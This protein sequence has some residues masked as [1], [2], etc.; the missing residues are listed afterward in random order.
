MTKT[1]NRRPRRG[2]LMAGISIAAFLTLG[3]GTALAA[4]DGD[5]EE[6]TVDEVVVT[7]SLGK[8]RT[9]LESAVPIDA[10]SAEDIEAVS[11]GDTQDILK[12]L[13]PS[14][15]LPRLPIA[16]GAT[17]I[18]PASLRGLSTDKTLLLVNSK[19]RHRGALVST[20]GDGAQPAD[21]AQI[22]A[23]ALKSVEVLRD[24]AGAQYGSDAIAGV[25]NFILKDAPDGGM[26]S[27]QAGQYY[28]G[29]GDEIVIGGN[30]GFAIGDAGFL[31]FSFEYVSLQPTSRGKQICN[32]GVANQSAGFCVASLTTAS[33][34]P[35]IAAYATLTN[36]ENLI[37]D[38]A[39]HWGVPETEAFR[40]FV[41]AGYDFGDVEWYAFANYSKSHARQ[42]FNYR[43][44]IDMNNANTPND[45]PIRLQDGTTWT[46]NQRFPLGFTPKFFGDVTDY[47]L[48]SGLTGAF[49]PVRYDVSARYGQDKIAY[50]MTNT[51][52]YSLGRASPSEFH[53][54]DLIS[55]EIAVNADFVYEWKPSFLSN[56]VDV[57]F[58]A[59]A[60]QEGYE[61]VKGDEASY[62][63][64]PFAVADPFDFCTN[65]STV[66]LRTMTAA[67]VAT[68]QAINC[69]SSSDPVYQT[70]GAGSNGFP[71]YPPL[72]A[73][74]LS[75]DSYAAYVDVSS[76]I[77][78]QLF[79]E[80]ALRAE[81]F[82]DFGGTVDYKV[83]AR[84]EFVDGFAIRGSLGTGFRAP[85][86]GQLFTTV[87]STVVNNGIPVAQGL[88]PATN[89][90]AQY[91]GGKPLKPERSENFSLGLTASPI[92][93]LN[94]TAD[95]YRIKVSDMFFATPQITVTPAIAAAM[96]AAGVPGA[97]SIGAVVFFQNAFDA[98]IQGVD[99]VATYALDWDSGQSTVLSASLNYNKPEVDSVK[100]FVDATGVTRVYFDAEFKKD[101]ADATPRWRSI[102][103]A[104]HTIGD[105]T[106]LVRAN[107]WGPYE[108][109]FSVGNPVIQKF[110]PEVLVDLE[111]SYQIDD[112]YKLSFGGR[113]IFDNYP[114]PDKIGEST[115]NG[116]I[117]RSDALVD[118][119]GGYYFAKL[120]AVF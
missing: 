44:P 58:G 38:P 114:D 53:P 39:Q 9:V 14:Y 109:Q 112:T 102:L 48:V 42:D 51:L 26:L 63:V 60:R 25:I 92:P 85:T 67:G 101:Y 7:G 120:T 119:Q 57:A 64:G 99:V 113:N 4:E 43:P 70:M 24:G 55:D 61:I 115:T 108:N 37:G 103:S 3:V 18:R 118:W 19:R 66:G 79:V 73:G 27:I 111:F 84:Y 97:D 32:V 68:G 100:P 49:G 29:D 59:E 89:P 23:S 86:P 105:F 96:T 104:S 2:T 116:R 36:Y 1:D 88:F 87:V 8:P 46:V 81:D 95:Y 83:A 71:G 12:V 110:D 10:H 65:E 106:T 28:E 22:P 33:A 62:I 34:T 94:I 15:T 41:N 16:D 74:E 72:Y 13:V 98:T 5:A 54:G 69:A 35:R 78:D 50:V 82:S 107:I 93:G 77:T 90:V 52:N 117:Y 6:P 30:K 17:F 11:Y 21:A 76:D 31:N 80:L 40:T 47:S 20:G 56:G 75:R 91:L 45:N